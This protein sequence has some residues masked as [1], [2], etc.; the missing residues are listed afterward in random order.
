MVTPRRARCAANVAA[1]R[2]CSANRCGAPYAFRAD[3][4]DGYGTRPP[5]D[6]LRTRDQHIGA[7]RVEAHPA[8]TGHGSESPTSCSTPPPRHALETS[9]PSSAD[10]RGVSTSRR[11]RGPTERAYEGAVTLARSD[12]HLVPTDTAL[13]AAGRASARLVDESRL[14]EDPKAGW[15]VEAAIRRHVETLA[16]RRLTPD[17]RPT[18][19]SDPLM[20]ALRQFTDFDANQ[21][22]SP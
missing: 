16:A 10:R 2:G 20:V 9:R 3:A 1:R 15:L 12:G 6:A 4:T 14:S 19:Q 18:D 8:R 22:L 13:V 5:P 21:S 7:R 11:P 17:T